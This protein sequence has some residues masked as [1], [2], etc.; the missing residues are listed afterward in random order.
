M[1]YA[2]RRYT[3]EGYPVLALEDAARGKCWCAESIHVT[4]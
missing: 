4:P 3:Y 1:I 2:G